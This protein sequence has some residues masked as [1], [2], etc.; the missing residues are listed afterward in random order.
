MDIKKIKDKLGG[1]AHTFS[2]RTWEAEA[3]KF[4]EFQA[5]LVYKVSFMTARAA[6]QRNPIVKSQKKGGI[7]NLNVNQSEA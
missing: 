2:L 1:V 4:C 6:A 5:S 3:H 7:N